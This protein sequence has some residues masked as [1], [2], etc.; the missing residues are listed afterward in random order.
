MCRFHNLQ[1]RLALGKMN[2]YPN[3]AMDAVHFSQ[4]I[5][6]ATVIVIG[7]DGKIWLNMPFS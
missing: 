5:P 6:S 4:D 1:Q 7:T 2:I 3:P